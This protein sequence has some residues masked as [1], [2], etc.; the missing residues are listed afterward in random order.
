MIL[1][2]RCYTAEHELLCIQK[3]SES[4]RRGRNIVMIYE[5]NLLRKVFFAFIF[6]KHFFFAYDIE[7]GEGC[8]SYRNFSSVMLT[9][10]THIWLFI[11][12]NTATHLN[13]LRYSARF[14]SKNTILSL[15]G[16]AKSPEYLT[17]YSEYNFSNYISFHFRF[18][19]V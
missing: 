9:N 8:I 19:T 18:V 14:N 1:E 11:L 2:T 16:K 13:T 4:S 17:T 6:I 7:S 3:S 5:T 10:N 12:N 15:D